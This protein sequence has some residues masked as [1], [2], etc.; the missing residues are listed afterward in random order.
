MRHTTIENSFIPDVKSI[1]IKWMPSY[2]AVI[3]LLLIAIF[4]LSV[5]PGA[6]PS[7]FVSNLMFSFAGDPM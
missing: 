2:G 4:A 3:A 7:E 5:H 1:E 6:G